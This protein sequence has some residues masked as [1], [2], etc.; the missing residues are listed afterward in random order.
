MDA[1]EQWSRLMGL[2]VGVWPIAA[3]GWVQ[4]SL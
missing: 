2:L 1:R 3:R 4:E